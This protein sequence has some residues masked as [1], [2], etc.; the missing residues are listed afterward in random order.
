MLS[1][2]RP[3]KDLL[4]TLQVEEGEPKGLGCRTGRGKEA[5]ETEGS[6]DV[7]EHLLMLLL[8]H[9]AIA[10]GKDNLLTL[11]ANSILRLDKSNFSTII[12]Q[13]KFKS[14]GKCLVL[15]TYRWSES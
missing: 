6:L 4:H 11:S 10:V 9:L 12:L 3:L 13:L 2:L 15:L 1:P 14:L 5:D 8:L 7:Y